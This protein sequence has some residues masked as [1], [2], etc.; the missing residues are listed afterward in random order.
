MII[1]D[2]QQD[3]L[4]Y[5]NNNNIRQKCH[6]HPDLTEKKI[7]IEKKNSKINHLCMHILNEKFRSNKQNTQQQ[8]K[9]LHHGCH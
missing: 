5:H 7:L 9:I 8:K 1:I 2:S 6:F 3:Y 4:S